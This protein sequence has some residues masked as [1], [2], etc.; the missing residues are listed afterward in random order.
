MVDFLNAKSPP[1]AGLYRMQNKKRILKFKILSTFCQIYRKFSFSLLPSPICVKI[2]GKSRLGLR[3]A[4]GGIP[5]QNH[6]FA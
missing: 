2:T 3:I 6:T 4:S 5:R 1:K